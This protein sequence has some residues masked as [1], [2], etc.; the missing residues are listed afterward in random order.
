MSASNFA[1]HRDNTQKTLNNSSAY[2]TLTEIFIRRTN[3]H[4]LHSVILSCFVGSRSERIVRL[5]ID[6]WPHHY[7]H[8]FQCFLENGELR[9]QLRQHAFTRLVSVT[10]G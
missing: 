3:E 1:S 5:I 9:E 4:L 8:C 10:R 2:H 6:H 7:S